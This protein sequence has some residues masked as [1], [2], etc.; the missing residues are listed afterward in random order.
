MPAAAA[1]ATPIGESS[2]AIADRRLDIEPPARL[3]VDVG[4]RLRC[5]MSAAVTTV[6]NGPPVEQTGARQHALDELRLGVRGDRQ[7]HAGVAQPRE[8]LERARARLDALQRLLHHETRAAR[9]SAPRPR[10]ALEQRLQLDRRHRARRA[11]QRPLVLDREL[12][13]APRRTASARRASTPPPYPAAA[14]RC[15]IRPLQAGSTRQPALLR[16]AADVRR[17]KRDRG[18][19]LSVAR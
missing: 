3:E 6:A 4:R 7:R 1:A 9:P 12:A 16:S 8:Q 18:R 15:R 14:R 5:S 11:D 17:V 10:P 13:P 2:S 19:T